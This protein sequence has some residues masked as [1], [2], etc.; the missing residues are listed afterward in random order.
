MPK[1]LRRRIS[2]IKKLSNQLED[3]V[4]ALKSDINFSKKDVRS[5]IHPIQK[6]EYSQ[7]AYRSYLP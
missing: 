4:T 7:F 1:T 6:G 5:S 2:T 3:S